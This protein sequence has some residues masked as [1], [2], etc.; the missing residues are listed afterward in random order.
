MAWA[1]AA[2]PWPGPGRREEGRGRGLIP[3]RRSERVKFCVAE[4]RMRRALRLA[5]FQA[6]CISPRAKIN[7]TARRVA[8]HSHLLSSIHFYSKMQILQI[9]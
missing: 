5:S 2:P 1:A 8:T 3:P 7:R 4:E 9:R 6:T